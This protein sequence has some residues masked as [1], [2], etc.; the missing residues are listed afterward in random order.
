MLK[1]YPWPEEKHSIAIRKAVI[2]DGMYLIVDF[3]SVKTQL[4]VCIGKKEYANYYTEG[5]AVTVLG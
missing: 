1:G 5:I 4:P 2:D 3:V